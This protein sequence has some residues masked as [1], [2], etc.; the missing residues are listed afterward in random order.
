MLVAKIEKYFGKKGAPPS[1]E[2]MI[3]AQLLSLLLSAMPP[4]GAA[5]L[6]AILA[7]LPLP[8][9]ARTAELSAEMALH[10]TIKDTMTNEA[11]HLDATDIF[12]ER[13]A[14]LHAALSQPTAA[15]L[16]LGEPGCGKTSLRALVARLIAAEAAGEGGAAAAAA[17]APAAQDSTM[18]SS[19]RA[20]P[21]GFPRPSW[22]GSA[23]ASPTLIPNL[24]N[25]SLAEMGNAAVRRASS[26]A[27]GAAGHQALAE[28]G[29]GEAGGG[30]AGGFAQLSVYPGALRDDEL[31]G[32]LVR[33]AGGRGADEEE[34]MD[35]L[36]IEPE[37]P[38]RRQQAA[39]LSEARKELLATA[40]PQSPR[41]PT[42]A[43][44]KKAGSRGAGG[45]WGGAKASLPTSPRLN[46]AAVAKAKAAS[47][48]KRA[49]PPPPPPPM[50]AGE[51]ETTE[52]WR[53]GLLATLLRSLQEQEPPRPARKRSEAAEEADAADA[54]EGGDDEE[55]AAVSRAG[56]PVST[57]GGGSDRAGAA[58]GGGGAVAAPLWLVFDGELQP[59]L[60]EVLSGMA[61][62]GGGAEGGARRLSLESGE[63]LRLPPRL[64]LLFETSDARHASPALLAQCAVLHVPPAAVGWWQLV[65]GWLAAEPLV[66]AASKRVLQ[67]W[68]QYAVDGVLLQMRKEGLLGAS[69]HAAHAPRCHNTRPTRAL[70]ETRA[71]V[72]WRSQ[73][74][75]RWAGPRRQHAAAALGTASPA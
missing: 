69:R 43:S 54:T 44:L 30:G 40:R 75:P 21:L 46:I 18:L 62:G 63:R 14:Q 13:A 26:L 23:A 55:A 49:E 41:T 6:D 5:A 53:D 57:A 38:N 52:Q 9:P 66:P 37:K 16:L 73:P 17:P 67:K 15:V 1:Q 20:Q 47:N 65:R 31:F 11:P 35:G 7:P 33:E 56:S 71:P 32:C 42:V 58:A 74:E 64:R 29:V 61:A 70:S 12:V 22:Q 2:R 51:A 59:A 19:A 39:L 50:K 4:N 60:C 24:P 28:S 45:R 8:M 36:G 10:N 3:V 34:D 25:T 72:W 27:A 48:A 68:V